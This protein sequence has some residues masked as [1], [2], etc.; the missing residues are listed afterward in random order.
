M[1]QRLPLTRDLSPSKESGKVAFRWT[2]IKEN[3]LELF[4]ILTT[5]HNFKAAEPSTEKVERE[6]RREKSEA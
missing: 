1:L 6:K 2:S 5:F 3:P 4:L